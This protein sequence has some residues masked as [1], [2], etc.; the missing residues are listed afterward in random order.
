MESLRL[1]RTAQRGQLRE[2]SCETGERELRGS[3]KD[4]NFTQLRTTMNIKFRLFKDLQH[5]ESRDLT[6][7]SIFTIKDHPPARI[8]R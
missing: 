3:R 5:G 1:E 7:T 8:I 4:L 6:S 2:D